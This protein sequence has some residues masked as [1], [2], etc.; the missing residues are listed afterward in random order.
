MEKTLSALN[1]AIQNFG[2][3]DLAVSWIHATA[4]AAPFEIAKF[5][6]SKTSKIQFYE[7][8]G[9]AISNPAKPD[10]L[11]RRAEQFQSIPNVDYHSIVLGFI[12][13][14]KSGRWLS[15]SEISKGVLSTVLLEKK[16]SIVGTTEPW[17]LRP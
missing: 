12:I 1:K 6:A 7:V 16:I 8:L 14:G 9:S 11:K 2:S 4:P 10:L 3:I 5:L 17:D 15:D 13:E